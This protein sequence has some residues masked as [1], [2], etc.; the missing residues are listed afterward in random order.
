MLALELIKIQI[1]RTTC[2]S[3]DCVFVDP[4]GAE[5]GR[6]VHR[7]HV[8]GGHPVRAALLPAAGRAGEGRRLRSSRVALHRRRRSGAPPLQGWLQHPH[9]GNYK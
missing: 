1:L 7:G 4:P 9:R 2:D 3:P 8:W 6:G 5:A